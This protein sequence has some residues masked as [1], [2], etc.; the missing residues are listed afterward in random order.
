M[1]PIGDINKKRTAWHH[2]QA[3]FCFFARNLEEMEGAEP[4]SLFYSAPGVRISLGGKDRLH[5]IGEKP[6]I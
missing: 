5:I 4:N 3:V 2:C 6:N 1:D